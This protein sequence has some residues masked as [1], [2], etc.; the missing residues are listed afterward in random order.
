MT[1]IHASEGTWLTQVNLTESEERMFWRS[2]TTAT[3]L[4]WR[5]VD[6][7]FKDKWEAEHP[8]NELEAQLN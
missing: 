6:N 3:P 5:E 2:I 8:I 1:T 4:A 7:A